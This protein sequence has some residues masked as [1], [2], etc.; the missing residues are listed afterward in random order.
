MLRSLSFHLSV[1]IFQICLIACQG[2]IFLFVC[3][4][5]L[6]L[7]IYDITL[8]WLE[9]FLLRSQLIVLREQVIHFFHLGA[10]KILYF[11][12]FLPFTWN[13]SLCGTCLSLLWDSLFFY[14]WL[15]VSFLRLGKFS[16]II[17][18]IKFSV[19]FFL[20]YPSNTI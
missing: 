7:W 9:I 3:F 16:A 4:V 1:K 20:N 19:P 10:F 6:S 12:F 17:P 8:F 2:K 18:L 14:T 5:L 11:Y 13:V 15:S